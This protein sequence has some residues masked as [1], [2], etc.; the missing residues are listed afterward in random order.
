[1]KISSKQLANDAKA[2]YSKLRDTIA[3]LEV[4]SKEEMKKH[5]GSNFVLNVEIKDIELLNSIS[6]RLEL[7]DLVMLNTSTTSKYDDLSSQF[8]EKY[9][10]FND[11]C[12][13]LK[14]NP[15]GSRK[16]A[17]FALQYSV[18]INE[19]ILC[20]SDLY[21][22]INEKLEIKEVLKIKGLYENLENKVQAKIEEIDSSFAEKKKNADRLLLR[23]EQAVAD[24]SVTDIKELYTRIL[25]RLEKEKNFNAGFYYSLAIIVI[26]LL[27]V[28]VILE[29]KYGVFEKSAVFKYSI[30]IGILGFI[31]FLCND[32]RKRYNIA[33]NMIDEFKQ[34]EIIVDTYASLLEKIQN[35]DEET[36]KAYNQ[37]ILKN[38]ISTL[39]AIKSHGYL[40]KDFHNMNPNM[41]NGIFSKAL[42]KKEN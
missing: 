20:I 19:L 1:M 38:I 35:F 4:Y 3:K 23:L 10:E 37:E 40:S 16:D 36:K 25:N 26:I 22:E 12:D 9:K 34:K 15:D 21:K 41:I 11:R 8:I 29:N 42:E 33:K 31:S 7:S 5:G 13:V 30:S 14:S 24:K 39:L 27:V 32:F 17:G 28:A 18:Y 2:I 6:Q